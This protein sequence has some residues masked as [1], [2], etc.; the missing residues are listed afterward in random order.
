VTGGTALRGYNTGRWGLRL[1][2]GL[3]STIPHMGWTSTGVQHNIHSFG[4][5]GLPLRWGIRPILSTHAPCVGLHTVQ[6]CSSSSE[7]RRQYPVQ[8]VQF[9]VAATAGCNRLCRLLVALQR[10]C[11]NGRI[12]NE[13]CVTTLP[14]PLAAGCATFKAD[15]NGAA[16]PLRATPFPI[17]I[18]IVTNR[19]RILLHRNNEYCT[20]LCCLFMDGCVIPLPFTTSSSI[21]DLQD[22]CRGGWYSPRSSIKQAAEPS[23]SF[24]PESLREC[25]AGVRTSKSL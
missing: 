19:F 16:P 1:G 25:E 11:E 9:Q 8:H 13:G 22:W 12:A 6:A 18:E 14:L 10:N 24:Y 4:W 2:W 7:I 15:G 17:L 21:V 5:W 3:D 20:K 23:A